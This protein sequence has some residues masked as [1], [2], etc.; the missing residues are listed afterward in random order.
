MITRE[1]LVK[2]MLD[3]VA[4]L[5]A[6]PVRETNGK[7]RSP[8]ID[9]WNMRVG[10]AMGAPYCASSIWCEWDDVCK[11]LGLKFPMKPTA[12]SQAFVWNVPWRYVRK[13]GE[14]GKAGD[15]G[16]LQQVTDSARG[17]LTILR[18]NQLA[19][20]YFVTYEFNTNR[21]G[22]R[23]GDGGYAMRRSTGDRSLD[24]AGKL[25]RAFVDIPQ[26]IIDFNQVAK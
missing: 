2:E 17:H 18:E 11:S 3:N 12:S 24:N 16:V 14:L 23:D 8:D 26:W 13:P 25:F 21:A 22:S 4:R 9:S 1:Q 7:N 19:Q 10:A 6:K 5:V 15:A 20:P